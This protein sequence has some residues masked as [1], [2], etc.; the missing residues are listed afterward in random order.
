M[1]KTIILVTLVVGVGC[2]VFRTI[3]PTPTF[4]RIVKK[5]TIENP[6]FAVL[7]I[8]GYY[9]ENA[10]WLTNEIE[11]ALLANN[12]R[13]FAINNSQVVS[14]TSGEIKRASSKSDSTSVSKEGIDVES[15][16]GINQIDTK[17]TY[18]F[19]ASYDTRAFKIISIK[20]EE[21]IASGTFTSLYSETIKDNINTILKEMGIVNKNK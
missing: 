1:K 3:M 18:L 8:R 10:V 16:I 4:E 17:A 6:S 21:I 13:L 15:T 11:T 2:G 7:I 12:V 9:P 5:S 14:K 20:T 19:K